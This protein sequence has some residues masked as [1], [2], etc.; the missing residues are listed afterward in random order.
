VLFRSGE[1]DIEATDEIFFDGEIT[2]PGAGPSTKLNLVTEGSYFNIYQNPIPNPLA[3]IPVGINQIWDY[4]LS[5]SWSAFSSSQ[6][7]IIFISE[8]LSPLNT[9]YGAPNIKQ[10]DISGS[11]FENITLDWSLKVG[12]E[13]RFEGREDRVYMVKSIYDPNDQSPQRISNTGSLEV[14]LNSPLPSASINLDHFLIRRYVDDA[15]TII[16]EGLKP[17]N[18]PGPYIIRPEFVVPALNKDLDSFIV[19]LTQKGLL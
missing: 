15:A 17:G 16:F 10:K 2:T 4:P 5:S 19:D 14:H 7:G 9:Y 8:S 1:E 18:S 12:D 3:S 13:F 11:G 6:A